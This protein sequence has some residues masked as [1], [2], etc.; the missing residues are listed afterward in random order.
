MYTEEK[1]PIDEVLVHY[2]VKGMKRGVR[3]VEGSSD[4]RARIHENAANKQPVSK[5]GSSWNPSARAVA[6]SERLKAM[7]VKKVSELGST[8]AVKTRD[9]RIVKDP[10]NPTDSEYMSM[11]PID[12]K[13]AD[14]AIG[15]RIEKKMRE[16]LKRNP[17]DS[18]ANEY[19]NS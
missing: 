4:A 1:P 8:S 17:N 16:R 12:R 5:S 14:P 7:R 3:K 15:A 11:N 6:V 13:K 10:R 2:G 19:L 18:V 9:G